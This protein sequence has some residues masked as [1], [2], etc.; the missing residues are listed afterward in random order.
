MKQISMSIL[1]LIVIKCKYNKTIGL[2]NRISFGNLSISLNSHF[3]DISIFRYSV[4]FL[5][6]FTRKSAL[7]KQ[8]GEKQS[9]TQTKQYNMK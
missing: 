3:F 6:L 4:F 1:K 7:T 5:F 2:K 8:H 9:N